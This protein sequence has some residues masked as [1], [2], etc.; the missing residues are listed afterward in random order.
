[1][2]VDIRAGEQIYRVIPGVS[3]ERRM[4]ALIR[5]LAWPGKTMAARLEIVDAMGLTP[6]LGLMLAMMLRMVFE[7]EDVL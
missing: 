1:M 6:L 7:K 3:E 5:L 2:G 4:L